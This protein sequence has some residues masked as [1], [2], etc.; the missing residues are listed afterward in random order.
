MEVMGGEGVIEE[1][2]GGPI[3]KED[4]N[5]NDSM[6]QQINNINLGKK[7]RWKRIDLVVTMSQDKSDS[8]T[9]KRKSPE[10]ETDFCGTKVAYKDGKKRLK[11][12]GLK[13]R[14]DGFI[15]MMNEN[16]ELI[17]VWARLIKKGRV[18]VKHKLM[19]E[20]DMLMAKEVTDETMAKIVDTK[21]HLNMEIDKDE[22]YW[23][24]R[25]MANWLKVG[26]KNSTFFRRFASFRKYINTISKL[27]LNGGGEATEAREINE[28]ATLYF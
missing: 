27:E 20:L 10:A 7:K 28:V 6:K 23:E 2:A 9:R 12:D 4:E 25:A 21:F 5:M 24:Q 26:D 3:I 19:K 18:G 15:D 16:L 22:A 17:D 1:Q 11:Q 13:D 14:D 8:S